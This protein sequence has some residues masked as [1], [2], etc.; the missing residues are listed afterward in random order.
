[1]LLKRATGEPLS[2]KT[3]AFYVEHK[4]VPQPLELPPSYPFKP[5]YNNCHIAQALHQSEQHNHK[6]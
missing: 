4:V 5:T 6:L 3:C 2:F 1:M